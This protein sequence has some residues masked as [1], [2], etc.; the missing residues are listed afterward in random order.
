MEV[1]RHTALPGDRIIVFNRG[2]DA[3][4]VHV[5][6]GY[7]MDIE[8]ILHPGASVKVRVGTGVKNLYVQLDDGPSFNGLVVVAED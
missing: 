2:P 6:D 4:V 8:S 7:G 3:K 5:L 1:T